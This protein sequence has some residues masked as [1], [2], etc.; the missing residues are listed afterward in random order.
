MVLS[1]LLFFFQ[2]EDGI[3]DL[4]VTGVQTCALPILHRDVLLAV[5]DG[6]RQPD[7]IR[8]DGG[9]PRPGLDRALVACRTRRVDFL[10]Q[11]VVHEGTL[12]D[13]ASHGL[14]L[15]SFLVPELNDHAASALVLAGLVTLCEGAPGTH[16][17]LARGRLAFT[18]AMRMVD[19]IHRDPAHGGP[20]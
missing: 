3:R 20:Y 4:Y 8:Q 9:A 1:V 11:M 19:R 15:V 12:L 6:D 16:R 18:S 10:H 7:E 14:A 17:I 5:V 2:A 13:R